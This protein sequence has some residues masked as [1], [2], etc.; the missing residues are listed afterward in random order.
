MQNRYNFLGW[1]VIIK[2]AIE[3]R[4][5][6]QETMS[7]F[8]LVLILF[9]YFTAGCNSLKNKNTVEK[10]EDSKIEP[11]ESSF[12]LNNDIIKEGDEFVLVFDRI[13]YKNDPAQKE[14]SILDLPNGYYFANT[15]KKLESLKLDLSSVF[16]LQTYSFTDEG[17]FHFNEVVTLTDFYE[18]FTKQTH[19]QFK[20]VPFRLVST[21]TKVDSLIEIYIP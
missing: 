18:T 19:S 4:I 11:Q 14:S 1:H 2:F 17:S 5:M 16:V 3:I 12:C 15:E 13:E 8:F 6:L 9:A 7:K 20:L 21:G 10:E